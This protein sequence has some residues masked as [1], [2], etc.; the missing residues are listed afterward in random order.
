LAHLR[1]HTG[2]HFGRRLPHLR[3]FRNPKPSQTSDIC[4]TTPAVAKKSGERV[5]SNPLNE[6]G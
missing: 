2:N 5:P 3:L 6:C 1:E 4:L